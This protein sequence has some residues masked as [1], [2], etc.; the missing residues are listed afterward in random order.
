MVGFGVSLFLVAFHQAQQLSHLNRIYNVI[1]QATL[2]SSKSLVVVDAP[3]AILAPAAF[4]IKAIDLVRIAKAALLGG[5][6]EKAEDLLN[7]IKF[8][9]ENVFDVA[10][11][12]Y[13][14]INS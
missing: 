5:L 2:F 4:Y 14:I 6:G 9:L 1:S 8:Y 10:Q 12:N 13:K 11:N 7:S 3:Q